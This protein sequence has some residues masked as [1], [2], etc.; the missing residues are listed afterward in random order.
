M[1]EDEQVPIALSIAPELVGG[2]F[3]DRMLVWHNQH[4]FTLDFVSQTQPTP[5]EGNLTVQIV[6]R[7]RVPP[8]VIFQIA[9]AIADNVDLY[10]QNFG[11]IND[12]GPQRPSN[13]TEADE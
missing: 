11:A 7:V 10:E 9:R 12:G 2:V 8:S 1:A 6:A 4:G 3:A 5:T 13:T